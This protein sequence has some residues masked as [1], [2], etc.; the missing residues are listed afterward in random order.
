[1][2]DTPNKPTLKAER[3]AS[4]GSLIAHPEMEWPFD[5]SSDRQAFLDRADRERRE[6]RNRQAKESKDR[7]KAKMEKARNA[8]TE[9][10]E[11]KFAKQQAEA[12]AL[13]ADGRTYAEIAIQLGVGKCRAHEL[14][15]DEYHET[16]KR[17]KALCEQ[18]RRAA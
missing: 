1:M 17:R 7:D 13:F 9:K 11:A 8:L 12:R 10:R 15:D 16:V 14:V 3:L 5:V 4:G 6:R 2:T 18:K